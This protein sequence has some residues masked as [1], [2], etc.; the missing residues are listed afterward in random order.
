M[1]AVK[2]TVSLPP[3][4]AR[5]AEQIARAEGKTLSGVV[6][7]ALRDARAKRLRQE[8]GGLQGHWGRKAK[9]QGILS[10]GDLERFLRS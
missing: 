7:D 6:Q 10:Q 1:S 4:L 8:L 3:D 9:E 2:K 5:A